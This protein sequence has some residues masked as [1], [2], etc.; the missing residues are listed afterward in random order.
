MIVS[1]VVKRRRMKMRNLFQWSIRDGYKFMCI[2][3]DRVIYDVSYGNDVPLVLS[4]EAKFLYNVRAFEK[5]LKTY[6]YE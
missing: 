3:Y 4:E 6:A 5:G 2:E 1:C